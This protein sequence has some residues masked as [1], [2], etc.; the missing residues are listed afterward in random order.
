[1]PLRLWAR[2]PDTTICSE[3]ATTNKCTDGVSQPRGPN[4][5]D[6]RSLRALVRDESEDVVGDCAAA[7]ETVVLDEM[8]LDRL[9]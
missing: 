2:A 4:D 6:W 1:M 9:A 5:D 8:S 3:P 7:F